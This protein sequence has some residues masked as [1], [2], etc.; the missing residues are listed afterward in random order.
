VASLP[1]S[2]YA[3]SKLAVFYQSGS[4]KW[5]AE[6]FTVPAAKVALRVIVGRFTVFLQSGSHFLYRPLRARQFI[7]NERT[8]MP[9][10]P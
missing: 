1:G 4:A 10:L 8:P 7:P 2:F 6:H 3:S 5:F 9:S